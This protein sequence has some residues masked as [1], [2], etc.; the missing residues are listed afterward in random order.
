MN[1]GRMES[2]IEVVSQEYGANEALVKAMQVYRRSLGKESERD[3]F[4]QPRLKEPVKKA[5]VRKKA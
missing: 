2:L 1:S 4:Q 3:N 5:G